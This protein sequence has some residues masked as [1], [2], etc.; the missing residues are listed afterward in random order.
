VAGLDFESGQ[1]SAHALLEF[2]QN[3]LN[4]PHCFVGWHFQNPLPSFA[5]YA[6]SFWS[7]MMLL[8]TS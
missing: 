8:T 1:I 5:A 3:Q 4:K 2:A 6:K 7:S